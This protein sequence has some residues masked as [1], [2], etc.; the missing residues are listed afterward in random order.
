MKFGIGMFPTDFS[1]DP[2]ELGRAAEDLG[3]E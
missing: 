1:I 3:F 2:V